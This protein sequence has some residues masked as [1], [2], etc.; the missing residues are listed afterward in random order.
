MANAIVGR[1]A[2]MG[3]LG[4][5]TQRAWGLL[6]AAAAAWFAI[7]ML[8]FPDLVPTHFAWNVQPRFAQAVIGAGYIFRTAFFLNVAFEKDWFRLRWIV[9]GNLVFTGVLLFST[10][11]HA[12]E[13]LWDP[14][15]SPVAH[16][17]IVLYVFEPVVMLYL[18]PPGILRAAAPATGGPIL[19][20]FR[21][22]LVFIT[23][24]LLMFGLLL[25]LNPEFAATRWPWELNPLDAR[26]VAAWALGWAVWCGT[27]AFAGDWHEIRTAARLF[28]LNGIA[29]TA[30]AI[31]FRDG[32]IPER[33]S[34]VAFT[35]AVATMTVVMAA[36]HWAQE[37]RA[38]RGDAVDGPLA[39]DP[40]A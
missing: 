26:I 24:I 20:P 36:F 17:W 6:G 5:G 25:L 33:G 22:F 27:M 11:W 21:W 16:I 29:L 10:Y 3:R 38:S 34:A 4:K 18:L 1:E 23:G 8:F 31:V 13:F 28:V 32:F 7:W 39:G 35:V 19:L 12:Q 30:V 9:W 14:F 40:I 2:A 37:R 15:Q